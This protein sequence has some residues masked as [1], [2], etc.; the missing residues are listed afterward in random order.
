MS[1][2]IA[3]GAEEYEA[4]FRAH[5]NRYELHMLIEAIER[6]GNISHEVRRLIEIALAAA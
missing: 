2:A 6:H 4:G 3:S 5:Q 1:E